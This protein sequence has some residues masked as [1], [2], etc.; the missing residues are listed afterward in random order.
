MNNKNLYGYDLECF[1][2]FFSIVAINPDN[3]AQEWAYEISDWAHQGYE[4]MTLL[5]WIYQTKGRMVGFNNMGY[6]WPVLDMVWQN[7]GHVTNEQLYAKSQAIIEDG[8]QGNSW[9]HVIWQPEIPQVD[10]YKIHHFDN[11]AKST[12]LK[13]LEFNMRMKDIQ[14]LPYDPNYPVTYEQSRHLL[15]YNRHDTI[16]TNDFLGYSMPML[17]FRDKLSEQHGKD[18]TNANDT[19]IGADYFIME[20]KK[21]GINANKYNQS[22]RQYVHINEIILPIIRFE[23]EKLNRVLNFFKSVVLPV[24]KIKGYFEGYEECNVDYGYIHMQFGAGGLHGSVN[25]SVIESDDEYL[26]IDSDVA[27]YYPNVPIAHGFYP[28]HLGEKFCDVYLDVYNQRKSHKKGTPENAMLKLALNGVY[29]KSNDIYSPFLDPRYT[30]QVT[31]NGQLMLAMLAEQLMKIPGLKMIQFN[32]DGLTYKCPR[33]YVDSAMKISEWWESLTKLELEH[34]HYS[35]MCVR[36]VNNYLAVKVDSGKVKRIGAYAYE[37]AMDDPATRELAWN[38]NQGA[39]V[40]PKAAEAFLVH[41]VP[42]DQFIRSHDDVMDFMLRTKVPRSA[43]LIGRTPGQPDQ[44]LQNITRYYVSNNGQKLVKIMP[45]TD[46]QIEQWASL[47]HWYHEDT[48]AHKCAA[49]PPSGKYRIGIRPSDLP[50]DREIGIE[51]GWNVTPCNNLTTHTVSDI[52]YEYYIKE[53]EKL[54]LGLECRSDV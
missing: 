24:H 8:K 25:N 39:V 1:P 49:K 43:K 7:Q 47:H 31:I 12:S 15:S 19:K 44:P 53:A 26:V 46:T 30:M 54:C 41:G 38:K 48:G 42:V 2:N 27:S 29:G 18:F 4:I 33:N 21:H 3:P 10:L 37:L 23:T 45:P 52:N 9:N 13:L 34:A 22:I 35:R 11:K 17:E 51:S 36:D 6:D 40:V 32:T 20:L 50:P 14:E 28:E 16:A 5:A